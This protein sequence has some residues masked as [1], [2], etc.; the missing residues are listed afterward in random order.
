MI[1]SLLLAI[2]LVWPLAWLGYQRT[3]ERARLETQIEAELMLTDALL[4]AVSDDFDPPNNVWRVNVVDGWFD[5]IGDAWLDPPIMSLAQGVLEGEEVVR[6]SFDGEWLAAGQWVGGNDVL[7]SVIERDSEV[8]SLR[9]AKFVWS[10]VALLLPL[11]AAVLAWRGLA[12]LSGPEQAA[13][14]VNREFIADAAHELRTPL[15]IIQASAGHALARDRDPV[16]YRE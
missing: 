8:S 4:F 14:A 2:T 13:H 15:S 12:K 6:F 7:L 9:R 5:P 1:W 11:G 16:E 10:L 3:A